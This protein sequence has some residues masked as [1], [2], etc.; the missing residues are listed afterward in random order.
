M[1]D[2][3]RWQKALR[4]Q[5]DPAASRIDTSALPLLQY[6]E[7][8]LGFPALPGNHIECALGVG[9]SQAIDI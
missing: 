8:V 4:E 9:P 5:Y 2:V 3:A 1:V 7:R 6:A